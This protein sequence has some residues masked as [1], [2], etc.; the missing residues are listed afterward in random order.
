VGYHRHHI[1]LNEGR[2]SEEVGYRSEGVCGRRVTGMVSTLATTNWVRLWRS[3]ELNCGSLRS[4]SG[5]PVVLYD[6]MRWGRLKR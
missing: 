2:L 4:G 1:R 3:K 6:I 5:E